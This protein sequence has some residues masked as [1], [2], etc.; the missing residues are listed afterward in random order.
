MA[1]KTVRAIIEAV[2][3]VEGEEFTNDPLDS[4]GKTKYG[5]T[6]SVAA[7]HG[8]P[9]VSKLTAEQAYA[10]YYDDYVI[11]PKFDTVL[12]LAPLTAAEL[13]DTGVNCGTSVPSRWLQE[14]LN[15]FNNQGTMYPDIV[16]D[17]ALGARTF[18]ALR[19]Y[20]KVRGSE[21]DATLAAAL[22]CDQG[23]YYKSLARRRIKDERFVY[24]WI[25]N[26]VLDQVREL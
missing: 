7:K 22:N 12:A 15:V 21:G 10:I 16:E 19:A 25:K 6:A 13:V 20:L 1:A 24:G 18:N 14:W 23:V 5:I 8:Y 11:G 3:G 4:G 2:M 26:R 17:G 9:D